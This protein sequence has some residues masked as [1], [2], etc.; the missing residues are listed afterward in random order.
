MRLPLR[1]LVVLVASAGAS[2][3]ARTAA[4][5]YECVNADRVLRE[6]VQQ[7]EQARAAGCSER[8]LRGT[9]SCVT[10]EREIERLA[11]LCPSHAPTLVANAVLA[12]E[13][14]NPVKSQ[15]FLDRVLSQSPALPDAAVLR[16]KLA[17]DEGNLPFARR[18]LAE[19]ITVSPD[20]AGLREVYGAALYLSGYLEDARRELMTARAM[21]APAWRVAYHLG[22]VE[23]ADGRPATAMA[24]YR[25]AIEGNPNW[26]AARSRLNALGAQPS[27]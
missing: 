16:A 19:R 15:Q 26:Q 13:S 17:I 21:G 25:E 11:F 9:G 6:V 24:H 12:Y 3:A 4:T 18:F 8:D 22:L 20:H 2:C 10:R 23:E 14:H 27:R 5:G 7:L 1:A